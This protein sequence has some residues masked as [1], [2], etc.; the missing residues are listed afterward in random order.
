MLTLT[1]KTKANP[2]ARKRLTAGLKSLGYRPIGNR[3]KQYEA[4]ES[5]CLRFVYFV[6]RDGELRMSRTATLSDSI[7]VRGLDVYQRL[8]DMGQVALEVA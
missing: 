8:L 1:R 3:S 6:G 2:D 5:P 7:S 4:L